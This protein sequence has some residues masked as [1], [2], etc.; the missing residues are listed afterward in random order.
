[1]H[2]LARILI[3][4]LKTT[5][6]RP[7]FLIITFGIPLVMLAL[8]GIRT[9]TMRDDKPE[10]L[11]TQPELKTEGYVDQAA[12]IKQFPQDLPQGILQPYPDEL[13]AQ[14]AMQTGDIQAYYI[15]P[16]SYMQ[17][18]E[19]IYVRQE[20]SP[21]SSENMQDWA[22]RWILLYN[23]VGGDM[24]LASRVWTPA[25][26]TETNL[27]AAQSGLAE[28]CPIPGYTC[29]S[30]M[31]LRFLPLVILVVFMFSIMFT[32]STL[33]QNMS[34][35][36]ENRLLEVLL[37]AASPGQLLGGK[38]LGLG[39]L[40]LLQ[41]TLWL[42][43]IYVI[44]NNGQIALSL[45]PGFAIPLSFIVWGFVF[46]LLGYALYAFM[47]AGAGA[48]IPDVKSYTSTA[49]IVAAPMYAG[50]MATIFSSFVPNGPLMVALSL[51]PFTSPVVMP[52]RMV[53][54]TVPTWQPL[55]AAALLLLTAVLM[56]RAV[57]RMF[58]AQMLLSGQPFRIQ[59]YL[60]ALVNPEATA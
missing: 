49:F 18:G 51:I 14:A 23:L 22:I 29:E 55:L 57:S 6:L 1:M 56:A 53:H 3:Y 52:W 30:S 26:V 50:Y 9:L 43:A 36:K 58:R 47:M 19:L 16:A 48:M 11:P 21:L 59:L 46:F 44:I 45:P 54:G 34:K 13:S 7:S 8:F 15:I 39:T 40:G 17:S 27:S 35:E 42:G 10:E 5:L 41:V 37:N 4:E 38:I 12:L 2:K 32:S 24:P 60:R 31:L 25:V 33:L 20:Y 28:G